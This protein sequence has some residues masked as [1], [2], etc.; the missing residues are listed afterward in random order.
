[1][2]ITEQEVPDLYTQWL[3]YLI[4]QT[5]F[6]LSVKYVAM[7]ALM[8]A[9][10]TGS[11]KRLYA[12]LS[13][14]HHRTSMDVHGGRSLLVAAVLCVH[15]SRP[16]LRSVRCTV[17]AVRLHQPLLSHKV[18]YSELKLKCLMWF[19]NL[20]MVDEYSMVSSKETNMAANNFYGF[21]HA[22][23]Q[24]GYMLSCISSHVSSV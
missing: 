22:G 9:Y 15:A 8:A 4:S 14:V 23:A 6:N 3:Q 24:Y 5:Q 18:D 2:T 17:S 10:S 11:K 7:A 13:Q 16:S 19:V 1:M 20:S 21:P 12:W